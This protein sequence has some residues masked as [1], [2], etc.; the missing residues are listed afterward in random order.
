MPRI[1][2]VVCFL[3]GILSG[4]VAVTQA[5]A[6]DYTLAADDKLII[7]VYE[8]PDLTGEFSVSPDGSITLP[9]VGTLPASG[10]RV[11]QFESS[12]AQ[13]LQQQAKLN[14]LPSVIVELKQ[15]RPFYLLGDVQQPGS[16]PYRPGLTVMQAVSI[17][18]GYFRLTDPG[19]LRLERDAITNRGLVRVLSLKRDQLTLR[20][21]RLLAEIEEAKEITLPPDLAGRKAEAGIVQLLREEKI[22]FDSNR[23]ASA[24]AVESLRRQI[25]LFEKEIV[26][27]GN[28]IETEKRQLRAVQ[29][30]LDEVQGLV[31]RGL[32]PTPRLTLLE[33]NVAQ[34]V[35]AQQNLETM[36]IRARQNIVQAEQK[37]ADVW[38][39][40]R[41]ETLTEFQKVTSDL[42]DARQQIDTTEQLVLEAEITTPKSLVPMLRNSPR[43]ARFVI[44]R[45]V[46][47]EP[48]E[49]EANGL[50]AVQPGDVIRVD[51]SPR[52]SPPQD[53]S[54][55]PRASSLA[56]PSAG[57]LVR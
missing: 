10:M 57:A 28:Q 38:S 46:A 43:D 1:A 29:K 2:F 53:L 19:L 27:L 11:D 35:S 45:W 13:R 37:I 41:K 9:V 56:P 39:T 49:F 5:S 30:E 48:Q 40:R 52:P 4:A 42:E 24:E 15:Y 17:G 36:I 23:K 34:I 21:A 12:I 54:S 8:W 47:S 16:Y 26:S 31:A 32:A 7:R 25:E 14:Q 3:A 50:T 33:R 55:P 44:T 18:G 20:R 6:A 51:R 22:V